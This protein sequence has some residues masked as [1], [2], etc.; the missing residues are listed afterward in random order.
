MKK[1]IITCVVSA[2]LIIGGTSLVGA[3]DGVNED[4]V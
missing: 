1:L 3:S 4:K 2:G